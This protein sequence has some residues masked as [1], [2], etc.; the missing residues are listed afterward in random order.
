M[1]EQPTFGDFVL[2]L[3]GLAILRAWM[4]DPQAVKARAKEIAEMAGWLGEE[5]WSEPIVGVERTVAAGYGESAASYDDVANP[6][7]LAEETVVRELIA[8]YPAGRALDA[9]CGTG[10]HAEFLAS[11]GHE[12]IGV[13]ATPEMLSVAKRKVPSARFEVGRLESMP[14]SDDSVDLAVCS[15]GLAHCADLRQPLRELGR[16]VRSGGAVILS[17]LHPF[18]IMLGG[19]AYYP[20]SRIETGFVRNYMHLP[21][22]FLVAFEEM[23]LEVVQFIEKLCG[24]EEIAAMGLT[25]EMSAL[26]KAAFMGVPIVIVWELAKGA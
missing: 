19:H 25:E 18:A 3:E 23:G 5:P 1:G 6:L 16:V 20:R 9:A 21:S 4:T 17:D 12:V 11:L 2:G 24:E 10:R 22:E 7:K 15:L 8:D 26:M 13:D 14:L